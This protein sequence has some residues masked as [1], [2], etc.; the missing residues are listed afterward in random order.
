LTKPLECDP[1]TGAIKSDSREYLG[2]R[3]ILG[4]QSRN[5]PLNLPGRE[6]SIGYQIRNSPHLSIERDHQVT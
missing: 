1:L 3:L 6:S 2:H 4:C 5:S